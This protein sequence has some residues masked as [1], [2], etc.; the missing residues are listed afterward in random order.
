MPLTLRSTG[1]ASPVYADWLD[2]TVF[3]DG[4]AIGRMYEDCHARPELRWFWS[5]TVFVGS[6]PHVRTDG[7]T[8]SLEEAKAQFM[9]SWSRVC[10]KKAGPLGLRENQ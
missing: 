1:L 8:A 9:S 2:Y 5:I 4:H 7:C 10:G 6:R 3:D